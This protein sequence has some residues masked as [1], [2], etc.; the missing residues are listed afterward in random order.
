MD[1]DAANREKQAKMFERYLQNSGLSLAFEVVFAEILTKKIP[2]DQVFGYAAMRLRQFEEDL[3]KLEQNK[4]APTGVANPE[5]ASK[6]V[7]S[8]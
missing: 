7:P 3:G 8:P 2:S 6:K 5:D 4:G 1:P